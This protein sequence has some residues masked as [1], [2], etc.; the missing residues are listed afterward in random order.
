MTETQRRHVVL[1][2]EAVN[3]L[4]EYQASHGLRSFSSAV[5]AAVAALA[6][7]ERQAAYQLYARD[8]AEDE[9]ERQHAEAWLALPMDEG[10]PR[11]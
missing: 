8:Y 9:N 7:Q 4:E 3:L 5:E 11:P 6:R 2:P 10:E 1:P